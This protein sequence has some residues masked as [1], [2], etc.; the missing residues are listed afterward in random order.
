MVTTSTLLLS[1]TITSVRTASNYPLTRRSRITL[2]TT[3]A[4]WPSHP[5]FSPGTG[6][7][8]AQATRH[9]IATEHRHTNHAN[10]VIDT[11]T[12]QS[13]EYSHLTRGPE[14]DIWKTS[15]ANYLGWIAQGVGT[16]TSTG[17][18]T[19]FFIPC[20]AIPSGR[21]VSYSR[22]V[23]IIRSHETKTHWSRVTISGN[24]LYSW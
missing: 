4:P 24:R 8:Y 3:S 13:L 21:T 19:V 12:G 22:L 18:N 23:A 15:L 14:K 1:S 17:T 11:D 10:T 20:S 5:V 9:L 6:S 2:H 16:R 7:C